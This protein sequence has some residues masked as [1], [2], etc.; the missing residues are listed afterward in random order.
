MVDERV[1][2]AAQGS[3]NGVGHY[4]TADPNEP[5]FEAVLYDCKIIYP[6]ASSG[7]VLSEDSDDETEDEDDDESDED[8]DEGDEDME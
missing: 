7:Q 1:G 8:E 2:Q 6:S 3:E 5:E 4:F